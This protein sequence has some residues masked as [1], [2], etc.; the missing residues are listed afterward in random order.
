MVSFIFSSFV[1]SDVETSLFSLNL[2]VSVEKV[3]HVRLPGEETT[4]FFV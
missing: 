2:V 4:F 1:A 3:R